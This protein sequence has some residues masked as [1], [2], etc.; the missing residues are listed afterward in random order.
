MIYKK[1]ASIVSLCVGLFLLAEVHAAPANSY[2]DLPTYFQYAQS[3]LAD[4]HSTYTISEEELQQ[5]DQLAQEYFENND[6]SEYEEPR[7]YTYLYGAQRDAAFLSYNTKDHFEGSLDPISAKIATLFFSNF[8]RPKL[9]TTDPY[10]EKLAHIVFAKYQKRYQQETVQSPTSSIPPEMEV[11]KEI[12]WIIYPIENFLPEPPPP[13]GDKAWKQQLAQLKQIQKK[14]T[15]KQKEKALFWANRG[16]WRVIVND[17]LF[18]N[19]IPLAK[20]LLVRALLTMGLYDAT[21][22]CAEAKYL[23]M[24]PRPFVL[25]P[26]FQPIVPAPSSPSYPSCHST[27]A[28]MAA[29]ILCCYLSHECD[30]WKKLSEEDGH[31]RLWGGV[32]YPMDHSIGKKLGH[33]LAHQILLSEG[34]PLEN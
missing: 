10:S 14:L 33:T 1:I 27:L 4:L 22:V 18:K 32:H 13:P 11:A 21:L 9:F 16:D 28:E 8:P 12:P 34:A 15:K 26:K 5:W 6:I 7:F 20:M 3:E 31:S 2:S 25:D 23:Y 24:V 19:D 29:T 30:H 17:Y